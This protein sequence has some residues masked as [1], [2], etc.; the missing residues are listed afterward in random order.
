VEN[1]YLH[2]QRNNYK[3][4]DHGANDIGQGAEDI[5]CVLV[6]RGENVGARQKHEKLDESNKS[7]HFALRLNKC[8]S[9]VMPI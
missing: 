8:E 6:E 3:Y 7:E 1:K 4:A 2:G 5:E 9:N